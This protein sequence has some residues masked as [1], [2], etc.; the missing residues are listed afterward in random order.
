MYYGGSCTAPSPVTCCYSNDSADKV[1]AVACTKDGS[2]PQF[3]QCTAQPKDCADAK[4]HAATGCA[5]LCDD[6][7]KQSLMD[8]VCATTTAASTTIV[9]AA[10]TTAARTTTVTT[11]A[12]TT[13]VLAATT[14]AARTT[15]VPATNSADWDCRT[16]Q[17]G[18]HYAYP[19]PAVAFVNSAVRTV[20]VRPRSTVLRLYDTHPSD[21]HRWM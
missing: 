21:I 5:A 15:T 8:A 9:P 11:A 16:V 19:T 10:T 14:T 12:S 3:G 4:Q 7:F 6:A 2:Q 18:S 1:D 13:T 17:T 20:Q